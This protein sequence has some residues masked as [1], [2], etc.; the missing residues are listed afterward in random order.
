MEKNELPDRIT[1]LEYDKLNQT[2]PGYKCDR[3]YQWDP[4]IRKIDK[5][6]K[7]VEFI[8]TVCHYDDPKLRTMIVKPKA[9][10]KLWYDLWS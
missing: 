1:Q 2:K 7:T 6:K 8:C 9:K 4:I 3:C 10:K 5:E